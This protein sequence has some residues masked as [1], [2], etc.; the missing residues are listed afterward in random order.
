MAR[1]EVEVEEAAE[2]VEG[3]VDVAEAGEEGFRLRETV[4]GI[5][6]PHQNRPSLRLQR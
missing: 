6:N 3:V 1:A 2:A 5:E 4:G